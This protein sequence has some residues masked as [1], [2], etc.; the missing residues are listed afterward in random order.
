MNKIFLMI[1]FLSSITY[2]FSQKI[3]SPAE[4][5]KIMNDSKISYQIKVLDKPIECKDYSDKL[6][7]HDYYRVSKDSGFITYKYN[8]N[9]EAKQLFD[10]AE[11]E[12]QSQNIDNALI[13]YKLALKADSSLS[14]IMTY[15]G[16]IY[17]TKGDYDNAI[18]WYKMAISRNYIDYMAHWFLADL[19][20]DIKDVKDAVDEI[21]IAQILNRNNQRIKKSW[22]NILEK[23]KRNS[24]DWC[25]NPQMEVSKISD[26]KISVSI[27]NKWTGYAIAKALWTYDP[28]YRELMGA[29]E[30]HHSTLEDRECLISLLAGLENAKINIKKDAQL[31]ILKKAL[32]NKHLDEYILYEI[33]LPDT[34]FVAF[35]LPEKTILDIKDYILTVR[36]T[37]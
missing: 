23:A 18:K 19:Y 11:K 8:P 4:L 28:G 6:N 24:E 13:D 22:I 3:H 20:S 31:R 33:I 12:F 7:Y 36:N 25:F 32:E 30:G 10:L 17:S 9:N 15:I 21:V 37:K 5:I 16:Q 29:S 1:V 26:N 34:P 35:Q 14:K 27:T 2:G